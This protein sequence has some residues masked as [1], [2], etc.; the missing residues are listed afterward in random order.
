VKR[1]LPVRRT[2]RPLLQGVWRE[3][4]FCSNGKWQ[5]K[6]STSIKKYVCCLLIGAEKGVFVFWSF[7]GI[8]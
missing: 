3:S 4:C 1:S 7:S 2:H 5:V 8:L 6:R